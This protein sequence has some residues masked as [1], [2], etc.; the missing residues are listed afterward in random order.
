MTRHLKDPLRRLS[1]SER[2]TLGTVSRSASLPAAQ[3]MHAKLLLGSSGGVE[4]QRSSALGGA[5]QQ[6][7]GLEADEPLQSGRIGGAQTWS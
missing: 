7:C 6:R 5:A 2:L 4:L 1:E 3:V